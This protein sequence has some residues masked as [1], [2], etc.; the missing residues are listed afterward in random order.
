MGPK[1]IELVCVC[2]TRVVVTGTNLLGGGQSISEVTLNGVPAAVVQSTITNTT[3]TVVAGE[4]MPSPTAG[5]VEI[6]SDT[7]SIVSEPNSWTYEELG[8]ITNVSPLIGQ[9]GVVVSL[10]GTSLVGSAKSIEQCFI[11]NVEA[12][13]F[14]TEGSTTHW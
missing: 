14:S 9:Q 5:A 7:G 8:T 6:I 4:G 13:S 3:L 1:K 2:V 11:A 12:V 10:T